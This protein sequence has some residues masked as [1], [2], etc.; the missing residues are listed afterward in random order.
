MVNFFLVTL[1]IILFFRRLLK[2]KSIA[3]SLGIIFIIEMLWCMLSCAYL[4]T[5]NA[6]I[7]ETGQ[8]SYHTGALLRMIILYM[9][10]LLI[11]SN[12]S[13]GKINSIYC[14]KFTVVKFQTRSILSF[15]QI[16]TFFIVCYSFLDMCISGI[17][18]FSSE[19]TRINFH[20]YSTL[21]L[22]MKIN[23]EITYFGLLICGIIFFNIKNEKNQLSKLFCLLILF[24]SLLTRVLMEY[25]YHGLYNVIFSFFIPGIIKWLEKRNYKIITFKNLL[26][27]IVILLF[28]FLG[29]ITI[30]S[31]TITSYDAVELLI[32][33]LFSLQSHTFWKIDEI[34]FI[35]QGN[36]FGNN[37]F[38]KN[39]FIAVFYNLGQMD[40]KSGMVN[41][42]YQI[43]DF[44][45]VVANLR[46]GVRFAGSFLTV[47]INTIGYIGTFTI[48]IILG[49]LTMFCFKLF[50]VSIK[51]QELVCLYFS[52][53]LLWDLLDYFRIGNYCI[54]LNV[55]TL[56]SIIVLISIYVFKKINNEKG[57]KY[58]AT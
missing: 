11:I 20:N 57:G 22:A 21:P 56:I 31:K 30:Y 15:L 7:S 34:Y 41:V 35:K 29:I 40:K 42:M 46:N 1:I 45:T 23:G 44:N 9:P 27:L 2:R 5:F 25:K 37:E 28:L 49:Y 24:I 52:Q 26:I 53:S 4:D 58:Y 8:N 54:I 12:E 32:N 36:I 13:S 17:P 19:I 38:L 14:Q 43:A 55:K 6:Y 16:V 50:Y 47:G 3:L 18:L 33:R 10:F 51:N 48:S 39:E